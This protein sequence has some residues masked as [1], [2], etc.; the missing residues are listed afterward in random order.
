MTSQLASR[1]RAVTNSDTA[2]LERLRSG[3]STAFDELFLRHYA[4]V[5]RV[6]YGVVG[7]AQD[8]HYLSL[9]LPVEHTLH[10]PVQLGGWFQC[11]CYS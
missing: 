9:R 8:Y 10:M 11:R 1:D 4:A 6:L 7:H 2:L 3:D 5:Y